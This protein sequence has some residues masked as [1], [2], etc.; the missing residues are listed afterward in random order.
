MKRIIRNRKLGTF[1]AAELVK[2]RKKIEEEIKPRTAL[3][4][5]TNPHFPKTEG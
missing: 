2:L 1:E 5:K 3:I 4:P